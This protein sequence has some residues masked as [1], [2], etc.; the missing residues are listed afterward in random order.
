MTQPYLYADGSGG[1]P[2]PG[3]QF[4]FFM[5]MI[6][7]E[8]SSIFKQRLRTEAISLL[9]P[10]SGALSVG[11]QAREDEID[12]WGAGVPE[13]VGAEIFSLSSVGSKMRADDHLE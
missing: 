3:A 10:Y 8:P 2:H 7:S 9:R 5:L 1:G 13:A 4:N 6:S 11:K 12:G